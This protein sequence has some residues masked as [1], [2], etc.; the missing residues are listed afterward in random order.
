MIMYCFPASNASTVPTVDYIG[1]HL[2]PVDRIR[3]NL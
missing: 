2:A 3:S 1:Y